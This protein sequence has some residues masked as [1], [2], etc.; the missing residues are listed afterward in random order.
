MLAQ[1]LNES[2]LPVNA[3]VSHGWPEDASVLETADAI[4]L[5]SDGNDKHVAKGKA[6]T[7]QAL[8]DRGV[9]FAVLHY[10]LEPGDDALNSFLEEAI[11]AYF[12]VDWSVNPVWTLERP[13]FAKHEITQ[14]VS[15]ENIEDE[16]YYHLRFPQPQAPISH[17]LTTVPPTSS[18]GEDGPRSGNPA[19]RDALSA[20]KPQSL[21]WA[22]EE[23]GKPRGFGFT[24]GHFHHNWNDSD[25]RKLALNGIAWT[26]NLA[27][28]AKGIESTITPIA[29]HDSI[30][31]AI[32]M[33]DLEDVE[34]HLAID[35][36][37]LNAPGRG[38]YTPLHQAILRKKGELANRLIA[39]GADPNV[40]TKSKQSALHIAISRSDIAA[41]QAVIAAGADLTLRDGSG[42][43]PLH[44]ATA[45]NKIEL[46]E[47]LLKSGADINAL[48]DAGGTPLHEASV[49]GS[50]ALIQLLLDHGVDASIVS[51]TGK[52][53]LDHAVE[54]K[55]AAAIELLQGR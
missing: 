10:A 14:G 34:R 12:E 29:K 27:I 17:L 8:R 28:P 6:E 39:L 33:G 41:A 18:L 36:K 4:V 30:E 50:A 2:G 26:A 38:S 16:W 40:T 25:F 5:Y 47:L 45:K 20:G 52:T 13:S 7:L 11:G 49:S 24:G 44:L 19:V 48:S 51:K 37:L 31:R 23:T 22:V 21:A 9:G 1:C 46:A 43:T 54:F 35:P 42:W 53:A 32:A 3:T 15:F 55:N